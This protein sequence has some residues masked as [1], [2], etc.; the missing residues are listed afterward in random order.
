MSALTRKRLTEMMQAYKTTALLRTAMDL[1]VFDALTNGP[2]TAATLAGKI[3][4]DPR[5]T[6]ILLDALT[7]V[8]LLDKQDTHYELPAGAGTLLSRTSPHYLGDMVKVMS[9]DREWDAFKRLTDAV[10]HG[11]TV[12]AEH[13]ETAQFDYW[14]DFAAYASAIAVPTARVMS[15]ALADWAAGR[16]SPRVLD[17]ACGHGIYGYTFARHNPD[18]RVWSLDWPNVLPVAAR[19]AERLGVRERVEL[20]PGDMF[21]EPLGG[22]Y[23]LVLITN[24]L[25]HFSQTRATELLRRAAQVLKPDGRLALVGFTVGDEPPMSDPL[26]YLFSILML[27]WTNEGEVH[28]ESGYQRMLADSGFGRPDIHRVADLPLRVLITQPARTAD[29]STVDGV[30][31]VLLRMQVHPGMEEEFERVWLE[32]D[33]DL[34]NEPASLHRWLLRSATEDSV[35]FIVSD[36]VD[37][38]GFRAFEDSP[39]H[40]AHRTK[41]HPYRSSGSF[42]AMRVVHHVAGVGAAQG[43]PR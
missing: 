42:T 21:T 28:T 23:D 3:G 25:H 37:E 12:L 1:D 11:G 26:P 40:L 10:R 39:T 16:Q 31:R 17:M 32:A 5:G 14:V 41:L 36:W 29:P 7:A 35:Y 20:L 43:G 13:A 9:G 18:A 22:P 8:G 24:V 38:A 4:A 30:F 33:A 6:R 2:A 19:H 15:N 27:V 34:A